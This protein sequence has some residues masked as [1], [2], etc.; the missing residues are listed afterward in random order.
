LSIIGS[1]EVSK[2][3]TGGKMQVIF[4]D[5]DHGFQVVTKKGVDIIEGKDKITVERDG[6][7]ILIKV[8]D[9]LVSG[10]KKQYR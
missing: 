5:G 2:Q 6:N 9:R 8:N 4:K 10:F 1:R 3:R 7:M